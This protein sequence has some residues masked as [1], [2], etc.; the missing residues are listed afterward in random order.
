VNI[1]GNLLVV[2]LFLSRWPIR[3]YGEWLALSAVVAYFGVTDMGMNS[4]AANA[5]TAAYSRGD[6]LRYRFLQ[7]SA[8]VFYLGMALGSVLLFGGL[9]MIA[10]I[11]VWI[12]I[13]QIPLSTAKWVLWLLAARICWQMP[14]AQVGNIYRTMGNLAATQWCGNFQSIGILAVTSVALLCH[15]GVLSLAFW[16]SAPLLAVTFGAWRKLELSNPDL[17]PRFSGARIAGIRELM[18]PSVSFGLIMIS[19]ALTA[20]APVL[21]VSRFMGGFAVALLVTSRTLANVIRQVV[22]ALNSAL[23]PELT[24]LDATGDAASLRFCHRL[25]ATGS[26][27]L[28]AAFAAALWFEGA[29]VISVW[30]RGKL[31]QDMWLLRL[32]LIALVLQSPWLASSLFTAASNRH[33]NLSYSYAGSAVLSVAAMAGL[34]PVCGLLAVPIGM[35]LGDAIA[36]YHFVIKDTCNILDEGY[37]RFAARLWLGL[38]ATSCAAWGIGYLGH[39]IAV[40]PDP[41]RW[42]QVGALTTLAAAL[43]SW[44]LGLRKD[45]RSRVAS[46]GRSRC[47]ALLRVRSVIQ[48]PA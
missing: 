39:F 13:H 23:W 40:G 45:D 35:I 10:P 33:R 15:R 11:P 42:L 5:M 3:M 20:Q 16:G 47:S 43:T 32:F 19:V 34:I 41:F 22:G 37:A 12:G 25:L 1:F 18:N 36:C 46:W 30:T 2:P 21:L 9:L 27:A 14:A 17:L 24:R 44:Q 6:Q 8:M 28:C 29:E 4:A 48:T 26:T 31:G 7:A 38:A